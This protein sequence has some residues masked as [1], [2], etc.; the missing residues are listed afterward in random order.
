MSVLYES[1]LI[2]VYARGSAGAFW[3]W[4]FSTSPQEI[5]NLEFSRIEIF[6]KKKKFL[7]TG[8]WAGAICV[9]SRSYCS[10][11]R[12]Y[13][14]PNRRKCVRVLSEWNS[15]DVPLERF[16]QMSP[17]FDRIHRVPRN[18]DIR[19]GSIGR[20]GIFCRAFRVTL[21]TSYTIYAASSNATIQ[22]WFK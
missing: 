4:T 19:T 9:S 5:E 14:H 15:E 12:V 17:Y 16:A 21:V 8:C 11:R 6:K 20:L 18:A 1:T 2:N 22:I 7:L 13:V 10:G 3:L